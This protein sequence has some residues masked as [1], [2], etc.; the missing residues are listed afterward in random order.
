M[1]VSDAS[2][3]EILQYADAT[4]VA[5]A[6]AVRLLARLTELQADGGTVQLCLTGGRIASR[7]YARLADDGPHS[8]VDWTRVGLW[9]G[10]ER[11]VPADDEDRNDKST[12]EVLREPLGLPAEL[13]HQMPAS[14]GGVDLDRAAADYAAEL[15]STT[16]DICLLGLGPD[17]HV[18]SLFPDHPSS[19]ASGEVIAVRHSP[20]PPPDRISLTL[21]VINR[22][23]EVWFLVS[24]EDKAEGAAKALTGG[25]ADPVPGALAHGTDR[26]VWLIDDA[27]ASRLPPGP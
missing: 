6:L 25:E 11:F 9:W 21:S 20:K 14:D 17:G 26:T 8:D 3:P 19:K 2:P 24:G 22:S 18:A 13:V 10:D 15:G 23:S 16:F 7:A 12:L 4:E 27:A 1:T 5:E